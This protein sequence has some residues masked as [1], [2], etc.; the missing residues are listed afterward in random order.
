MQGPIT[1]SVWQYAKIVFKN[2]LKHSQTKETL[3]K[4]QQ[5]A[6]DLETETNESEECESHDDAEETSEEEH[7]S[8]DL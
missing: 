8:L 1:G 7:T 3:P 6:I 2:D 5:N 4:E